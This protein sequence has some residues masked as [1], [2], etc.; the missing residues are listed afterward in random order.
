[1]N[2]LIGLI[3]QAKAVAKNM[4]LKKVGYTTAAVLFVVTAAVFALAPRAND[5]RLSAQ[6]EVVCDNAP[7]V[8][9]LNPFP[10]SFNAG[11]DPCHDFP[12]LLAVYN[13]QR[14]Q[15]V[16]A[17]DGQTFDV[18]SYVHNG[19][20][21]G[22]G[23][24]QN[25]N[26]VITV[27]DNAEPNHV[28]GT[29][30]T[31]SNAG[32]ITGAINITTASDEKLQIVPGSQHFEDWFGNYDSSAGSISLSSQNGEPTVVAHLNDLNGCFKYSK[33]IVFTVRVVKTAPTGQNT[34]TASAGGQIGS[35]CLRTGTVDWTNS[36]DVTDAEITV[37]DITDNTATQILARDINGH[38]DTPWLTPN[39]TYLY[40]MY[41]TTNGQHTE[42]ARKQLLVPDLSC[43]GTPVD[44]NFTINKTEF[45]V[46]EGIHY[47]ITSSPAMA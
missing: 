45:C 29:T 24:A 4:S 3:G 14:T 17:S 33:F 11:Q 42:L 10:T 39:H 13:G 37:Q 43:G 32:S 18:W 31:S 34:L 5:P 27:N 30:V 36:S 6:G 20:A 26:A 1:M 15:Q 41:N 22:N 35:Q 38:A 40:I 47:T 19:T 46:G 25:I 23:Y 16:S 2:Q 44:Y 28:I 9:T 7:S 8:P 12:S 21:E